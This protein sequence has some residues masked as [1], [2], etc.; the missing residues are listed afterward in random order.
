MTTTDGCVFCRIDDEDERRLITSTTNFYAR[1]DKFPVS[2]GHAEVVPFRHIESFFDLLTE[3]A[4]EAYTLMREVR[5]IVGKRFHP[6][7]FNIGINDGRAAGRTIHH[8]H[9]HLIPRYFGDVEDPRGGVRN[10][11]PSTYTPD[12][13]SSP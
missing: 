2:R 3:E 8:L 11:L 1:Y 13:W 7:G 10:I 12:L 9:I 5:N 4:A 6:D